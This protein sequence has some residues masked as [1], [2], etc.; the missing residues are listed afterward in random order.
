MPG[1][2][3]GSQYT[4]VLQ[5]HLVESQVPPS[6]ET[7][8]RTVRRRFHANQKE[9]NTTRGLTVGRCERGRSPVGHRRVAGQVFSV[10]HP[11]VAVQDRMGLEFAGRAGRLGKP[12]AQNS[13]PAI[14]SGSVASGPRSRGEQDR[15]HHAVPAS[16]GQPVG[17]T[18]SSMKR[19]LRRLQ[20]VP[21]QSSGQCGA[22]HHMQQD[23][24]APDIVARRR[25][26]Q[27]GSDQVTRKCS[28]KKARTSEPGFILGKNQAHV[29]AHGKGRRARRALR[30]DIAQRV[31]DSAGISTSAPTM[32]HRNMKVGRIPMSAW[33]LIGDW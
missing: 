21:P 4:H 19:C 2:P 29:P 14:I 18:G 1:S 25:L 17:V 27:C 32:F 9:G 23:L 13:S 11:F 6:I 15:R 31:V 20:P 22:P 8:G 26:P 30:P 33:N 16:C 7:I 28:R 10:D 24:E 5:E 3:T 12:W